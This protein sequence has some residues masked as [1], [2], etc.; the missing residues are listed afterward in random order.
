[1][2]IIPS[3]SVD[4]GG[5]FTEDAPRPPVPGE[6]GE[7]VWNDGRQQS[8][9]I[10]SSK[11]E[12]LKCDASVATPRRPD[13][14]LGYE[15]E[16]SASPTPPYLK[17]A[18]SLHSLLDD[19]D[20]INLFR[21]FLRQ[22][23]CADMLD[24]WF[25]CSGFRKLETSEDYEEKKV[26]TAKVIYKKY[27][28]DNS[29]IVSR[30]IKPATKSF[31]KD[32]VLKHHIDPAMFDQAQTE[33][34]A[35]IEENTYPLF[36]KSDLYLEYTRTGGESPKPTSDQNSLIDVIETP[37]VARPQDGKESRPP[38]SCPEPVNLCFVNPAQAPV[39]SANDS[40]QQSLSSDADTLSL[41]DSSLDGVPPYRY[42]KQHRREIV[43]SVKANGRVPLPHIPRPNRILKD[44][45]VD[46]ERFAA[47]LISKLEGVLKEREA[48]ERLGEWLQ[49]VGL[50]EDGDE[51]NPVT[52]IPGYRPPPGGHLHSYNPHCTD[53]YTGPFL[54]DAHE[55]NPES[56]LD[57]HVQRVMKSPG[58][59]S[60]GNRHSPT[61]RSPDGLPS[62]GR[63]MGSAGCS[64]QGKH[65]QRHTGK[66][67]LHHG[68]SGK[69][70]EQLEAEARVHLHWG[71]DG[72]YGSR[73]RTCADTMGY[74]TNQENTG[75]SGRG[76]PCK[77]GCK[78][79]EEVRPYE[80]PGLVEDVEKNQKILLW[81]MDGQKE[82]VRHKRSP[83][84]SM[85]GCKKATGHEGLHLCSKDRSGA[86]HPTRNNIQPSHPF[87]QDPTMPP[88]PAPNPLT[89][90]EEVC[91]RLEEENIKSGA[92]QPKQRYVMEVIQRGRSAVRPTQCPPV[93]V[94][95]AVSDSELSESEHR[96]SKKQP[97]DKMTVAYYLCEEPIP[98]TTSVERGR[99]VTLGQFKELLTKKGNYRYYFKKVS[100]EFDCGVVFEEVRED[101]AVLPIFE[102]KIIG[103]VE[104]IYSSVS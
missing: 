29:G 69:P 80:S 95:P 71:A 46:P 103:K 39:T 53:I 101:D 90:L 3:F 82:V 14:D 87:I 23:E 5:S 17:W 79:S 61:S 32:C 70:R 85:T 48:E 22:E 62:V 21:M 7:L 10:F 78:R 9:P 72:H 15:P 19:E 88:N 63:H 34:Q 37:H 98:Y 60:P 38:P 97:G 65:A 6:E 16:G 66:H 83:Y 13:L 51:A 31:I 96:A 26:K 73:P 89:Q 81:L 58:G 99:V 47:E 30:Q 35:M 36:L 56:I 49:R 92:V 91:R 64:V 24:F 41:T 2:S 102:E 57:D 44:I 33:I 27:I 1:M 86:G 42:R 59:P 43:D 75:Y 93:N 8:N 68:S 54:R 84:G 20:G 76:G 74:S 67:H 12:S 52:S 100:D 11:N 40:E 25:A 18:E 4:L 45:H 94:V 55:E 50:E 77:R 104:K 28:L